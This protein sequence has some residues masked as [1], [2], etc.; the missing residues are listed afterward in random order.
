[1]TFIVEPRGKDWWVVIDTRTHEVVVDCS[2]KL[3]AEAQAYRL[4]MLS[5][6]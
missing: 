2:S 3:E 5:Q 4:Q 6:K 1:M